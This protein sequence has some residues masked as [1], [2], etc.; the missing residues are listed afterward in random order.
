MES[1]GSLDECLAVIRADVEYLRTTLKSIIQKRYSDSINPAQLLQS[2]EAL[3]TQI[4]ELEQEIRSLADVRFNARLALE[5]SLSAKSEISESLKRMNVQP[6]YSAKLAERAAAAQQ[7]LNSSTNTSLQSTTPND[8][9]RPVQQSAVTLAGRHWSD[10]HVN[11]SHD[12]TSAAATAAPEAS[13]DARVK[14]SRYSLAPNA[15]QRKKPAKA[16]FAP[17]NRAE[18]EEVPHHVR[19]H[20]KFED[21]SAIYDLI[22]DQFKKTQNVSFAQLAR[23]Q[24]KIASKS[25]ERALEILRTLH[26]IMIKGPEREIHPYSAR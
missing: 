20:C 5:A 11:P 4:P 23:L 3:G 14:T 18:F 25:G 2:I 22:V 21:V 9:F 8:D 1:N 13:Q 26:L 7:S 15:L 19:S 16:S 24:P 10:R 12:F 6:Q 17:L